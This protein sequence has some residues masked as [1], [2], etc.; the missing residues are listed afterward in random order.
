MPYVLHAAALANLG[1]TDEA[2]VVAER[3]REVEPDLTVSTAIRSARFAQPG[4]NAELGDA[5]IRAG[6]PE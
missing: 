1:R 3:L 4:K 6:L 5:L 2:R